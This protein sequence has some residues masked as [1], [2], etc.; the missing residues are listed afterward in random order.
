[1]T[2]LD[3]LLDA[4][5]DAVHARST[6]LQ[7]P[8]VLV[9]YIDAEQQARKAIVE[10]FE[11]FRS[12]IPSLCQC[13]ECRALCEELSSFAAGPETDSAMR[14][15]PVNQQG[16]SRENTPSPYDLPEMHKAMKKKH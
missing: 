6:A 13:S 15:A 10:L 8:S 2:D 3:A 1:M 12:A 5:R 7:F 11:G 14:V 4:Y 9:D 16:T